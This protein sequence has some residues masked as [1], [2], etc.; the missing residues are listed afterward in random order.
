MSARMYGRQGHQQGR[1]LSGLGRRLI[2]HQ[3]SNINTIASTLTSTLPSSFRSSTRSTQHHTT[4]LRLVDG[5]RSFSFYNDN[6]NNN[7]NSHYPNMGNPAYTV[8]G[9]EVAF[10]MKA[11]PPEFRTLPSGT[12][13]LDA[14]KRGRF[15]FE[16]TPMDNGNGGDNNKRGG[17]RWDAT[18]RFALTA[19]EAASLLAR[20]DRGDSAVDFTRRL[21]G[22]H[23]QNP[24]GQ[25]L[26]KV[27]V[28]KAIDI[29]IE[30][31]SD[32][33]VDVD[34]DVLET[35]Q[36]RNDSIDHDQDQKGDGNGND[37]DHDHDHD[38]FQQQKRG[39]KT[40]NNGISLLVDYVDPDHQRFGLIPHPCSGGGGG[41]G[42]GG[43]YETEGFRGP[44]E[45]RLMIGEYQVLRSILESSIPKLVGWTT[46]FDRNIEQAIAKSVQGGGN[47]NGGG[48]GSGGNYNNRGGGGGGSNANTANSP[49]NYF[50]GGGGG[51]SSSGS[52]R[53]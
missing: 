23:Y 13:V 14:A 4:T 53:Q 20:L 32:V 26:D 24:T 19:E 30:V 36:N 28:A 18:T 10:T 7:N 44:F 51:G 2:Q 25:P 50:G 6:N 52:Y 43:M 9:E 42:G 29:E 33:D 39:T 16:W 3:T 47:G 35:N 40:I 41:G 17:Y 34:T 5:R 11:I 45:V 15:L 48:S 31:E 12:V 8:Y 49:H 46:M 38:K 1:F 27:F 22:D 37:N 21:P